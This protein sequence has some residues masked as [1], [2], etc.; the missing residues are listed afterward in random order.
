[1][2]WL[3]HT[4]I[5]DHHSRAVSAHLLR[6][7][8][9]DLDKRLREETLTSQRLRSVV[10]LLQEKLRTAEEGRR[11]SNGLE[12]A[13]YSHLVETEALVL[14][15]ERLVRS[16]DYCTAVWLGCPGYGW[17]IATLSPKNLKKHLQAG[18]FSLCNES[19]CDHA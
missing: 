18:C 15:R 12:R 8:I 2:Y 10:T 14:Q 7:Q 1:M 19:S 3:V 6:R 17:A 16:G 5:N 13:F 11:R 4:L 9:D